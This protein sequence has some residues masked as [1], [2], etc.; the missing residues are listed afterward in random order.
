MKLVAFFT[1]IVLVGVTSCQDAEAERAELQ[2]D[3]SH[4]FRM[5]DREAMRAVAERIDDDDIE[6]SNG[7]WF[8]E[9]KLQTLTLIGHYEDGLAVLDRHMDSSCPE[10]LVAHG[11]VS[12]LVGNENP[13]SFDT[14][15]RIL[16]AIPIDRKAESELVMEYYLALIVGEANTLYV[17]QELEPELTRL[18]PEILSSYKGRSRAELLKMAPIG[19]ISMEPFSETSSEPDERWWE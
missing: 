3:F 19:F 18:V 1:M 5:R 12:H 13:G 14:A 16:K 7:Q 15:Y 4:A 10:I 2:R 11:L 6:G 9:T 8:L 17:Q